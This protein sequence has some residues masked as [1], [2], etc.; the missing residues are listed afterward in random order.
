VK[1]FPKA[2]KAEQAAPLE[3]PKELAKPEPKDAA[4]EKRPAAEAHLPPMKRPGDDVAGEGRAFV[5]VDHARLRAT[6]DAE[7]ALTGKLDLGQRVK[8]FDRAGEWVLVVVEPYGPAGFISDRL[9]GQ[10]KP[11]AVLAKE[12][13]FSN[14]FVA[15]DVSLD[16]CLY[17]GKQQHDAC[18]QGCGVVAAPESIAANPEANAAMR[19][20]E[21]C[22][23]AFADCQR[24]CRDDEKKGGK[25]RHVLHRAH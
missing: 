24:S 7:G 12:I 19:C 1:E 16:D 15:D 18:Q 14:C 6:A 3:A 11:I 22:R 20:A 13:E 5:L 2:A 17:Q 25:K 10:R 9:L 23:V 4:K 21:A 8:T